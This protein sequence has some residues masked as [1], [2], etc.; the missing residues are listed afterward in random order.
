MLDSQYP[1][2]D[3]TRYKEGQNMTGYLSRGVR[4]F[5]GILCAGILLAFA[6]GK[7]LA[8]KKPKTYPETGKVVGLGTTGHTRS[9]ST[10]YSHTYKVETDTTI[11]MLD[12]GKLPLISGTG[13]ECGGEQRKIQLGDVLHF[14]IEKNNVYISAPDSTGAAGSEEEKLRIMSQELKP[15]PAAE[16]P[17]TPQ[18]L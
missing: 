2:G 14:R 9:N 17:S 10:V 7:A 13:G 15:S 6:Q 1:S 11:F 5:A 12:C 3:N 18:Q 16:K 4:I 8:D